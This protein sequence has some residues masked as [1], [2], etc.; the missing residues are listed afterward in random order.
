MSNLRSWSLA[1]AATAATAGWLFWLQAQPLRWDLERPATCM[2]DA[3]FCEGIRDAPIRQ[4]SNTWSCLV[5]VFAG[6]FILG[7]RGRGANG[8]AFGLLLVFLGATSAWFHSALTFRSEWWDG[9]FL[10]LIPG[11]L[12]A[13]N[14]RRGRAVD[15]AG[16][17]AALALMA[18]ATGLFLAFVMTGRKQVFASLVALYLL[19]QAWASRR[20]G[21]AAAPHF[22]W[23]AVGA[24]AAAFGIWLLDLKRI[25]CAPSSAWQG[26]AVWHVLCAA[27]IVLLFLHCDANV[28][29]RGSEA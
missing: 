18:A 21:P 28:G 23:G 2:P 25:V 24:F 17:L 5:Y 20:A 12:I 16:F 10:F 29:A 22:F 1:F 11:Y 14:L 7:L 3:C 9:L 4:P 19:S 13:Y 27:A 8:A 26:H 15:D 6:G